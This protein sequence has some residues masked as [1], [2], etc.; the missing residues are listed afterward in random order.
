MSLHFQLFLPPLTTCFYRTRT[1]TPVMHLI[2]TAAVH[3]SPDI[4]CSHLIW[5]TVYIMLCRTQEQLG[6][7]VYACERRGSG[8]HGLQVLVQSDKH[9]E[10]VDS[11]I[12]A[13]LAGVQVQPSHPLR[14]AHIAHT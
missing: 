11:R 7:I 4:I 6:Y 2:S 5:V 14:T 10:Y 12:E 1:E 8:V 3:L 13:F 9:P